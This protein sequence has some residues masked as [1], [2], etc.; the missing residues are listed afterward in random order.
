MDYPVDYLSKPTFTLTVHE[1]ILTTLVPT[2]VHWSV[3][4]RFTEIND[5]SGHFKSPMCLDLER[6]ED[7]TTHVPDSL[8]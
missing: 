8:P 7:K 4:T 1:K 3:A 6:A 2:Y 5:G